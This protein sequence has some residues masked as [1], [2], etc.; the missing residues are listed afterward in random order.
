MRELFA[1]LERISTRQHNEFAAEARLHN[2]KIPFKYNNK[3]H[4][5]EFS[6]A[7]DALLNEKLIEAQNRKMSEMRQRNGQ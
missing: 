4:E 6:P 1:R 7:Q 5:V 3:S 2:F